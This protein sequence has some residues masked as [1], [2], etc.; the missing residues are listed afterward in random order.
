MGYVTITQRRGV[1]IRY[2][3]GHTFLFVICQ[4][5]TSPSGNASLIFGDGSDEPTESRDRLVAGS[6]DPLADNRLASRSNNF[7]HG[8]AR[9]FGS[10][11]S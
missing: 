7:D 8:A 5:V 9:I 11:T 4:I 6:L 1:T 3:C 2:V 10:T